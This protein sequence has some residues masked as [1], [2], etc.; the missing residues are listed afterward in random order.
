MG[1]YASALGK[2]HLNFAWAG[3]HFNNP[4]SEDLVGYAIA[5][6]KTLFDTITAYG[7]IGVGLYQ[8]RIRYRHPGF[9][10]S[11]GGAWLARADTL[12][13]TIS[14]SVAM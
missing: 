12:G 8:W 9:L 10:H 11:R 7:A 6:L 14:S 5:D 4:R 2:E 3:L 1:E 13:G